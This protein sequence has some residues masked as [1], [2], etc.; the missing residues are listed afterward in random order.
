MRKV[1][2]KI[3]L[4][5]TVLIALCMLT[6]GVFATPAISTGSTAV[7]RLAAPEPTAPEETMPEEEIDD[8]LLQEVQ[9]LP[10]AIAAKIIQ[11]LEAGMDRLLQRGLTGLTEWGWAVTMEIVEFLIS[12]L[13][14]YSTSVFGTA[15]FKTIAGVFSRFG[16]LL[17]AVGVAMAFV[18]F[19]IEY[20]RKGADLTGAML[21]FGKGLIAVSLFSAVPVPLFN[22]C[23]VIG[24]YI[25]NAMAVNWSFTSIRDALAAQV[26]GEIIGVVLGIVMIILIFG[27]VFD[28]LKRGGILL[29]QICVGSLHMLSVPRGYMD[30]FYAWCRQVIAL[31]VTVLLQ[32]LLLC[33]GLMMI[34][35]SDWILVGIGI[36]FAA[37]EV[38]KICERFGMDTSTKTNFTNIAIGV[39]A[40]M[41]AVRAATT[42]LL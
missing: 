8:P 29:I 11:E 42:L 22:F 32:N 36:L 28:T 17:F 39:N 1:F 34:P 10:E 20:R 7:A 35:S 9:G 26:G 3:L 25:L 6:Q 27:I 19:G 13:T 18:D 23:V 5:P 16:Q 38:P 2:K 21:N 12:S 41:Q 24:H 40:A 15:W 33:C 37:K 4:L 14:M 30:G 31:C